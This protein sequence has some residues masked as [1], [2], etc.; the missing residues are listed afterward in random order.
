MMGRDKIAEARLDGM[1]YALRKIKEN[2]IEAFEKEYRMR[3]QYGI[4]FH[5]PKAEEAEYRLHAV[6][7]LMTMMLYTLHDRYGFGKERCAEVMRLF[8][9]RI[10][11]VAEGFV[12]WT[13]IAE[14]MEKEMDIKVVLK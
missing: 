3:N 11:D 8:N 14:Q 1:E 6:R 7:C 5:S 10:A 9:A 4:A 13:E 2:G 12:G